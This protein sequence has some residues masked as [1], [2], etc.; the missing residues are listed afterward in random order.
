MG[1]VL[2]GG[3]L[4]AATAIPAV[5][6]AALKAVVPPLLDVLAVP[7]AAPLVWSHARKVIPA[8]TVPLKFAAGT[9][10][11]RVD[12]SAASRRAVEVVGLPKLLQLDPPL[13]ENCHVPLL[14]STPTTA[15][16]ES[17]A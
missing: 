14:L 11:T 5:A 13:R 9:K 17:G 6:V 7:P 3:S 8:A 12:P 10:R 15:M 16:P 4:T 1:S 2:T